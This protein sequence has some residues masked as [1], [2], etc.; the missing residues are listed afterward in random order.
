MSL[1]MYLS[2]FKQNLYLT[3]SVSVSLFLFLVVALYMD[4]DYA[5]YENGTKRIPRNCIWI[6]RSS[7]EVLDNIMDKIPQKNL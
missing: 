7:K 1:K 2:N 6:E 4:F 5:T 3:I